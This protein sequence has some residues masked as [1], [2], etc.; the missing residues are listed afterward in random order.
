VTSREPLV[1]SLNAYA[2]EG[3]LDGRF[4]PATCFNP[5]IALGYVTAP[6]EALNL[7]HHY[8][9]L[10]D[11]AAIAG[12]THLQFNL[13]WARLEP[14]DGSFDHEAFARYQRAFTYATDAGLVVQVG[15]CDGAWPA[16]LGLEPW[17]WPWTESVT[18]RYLET[19]A[20]YC[21][22]V[23]SI[24]VLPTASTLEK[25]FLRADGPPWRSNAALDAAAST[26]RLTAI[27]ARARVAGLLR[28]DQ[29]ALPP[30]VALVAGMGPLA[31]ANALLTREESQ[32][33]PA[34]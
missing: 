27:A 31:A 14:H 18:L 17:L 5:A 10:I 24:S 34:S 15:S 1:A 13:S 2:T 32:W 26:E 3:G 21:E 22:Q 6:G 7:W 11:A 33:V 29:S 8:E 23:Q 16:W 12:V 4:Q 19:L 9:S 30:S 25:G 28:D 20:P